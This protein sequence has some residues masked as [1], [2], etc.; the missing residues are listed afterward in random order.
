MESKILAFLEKGPRTNRELREAMKGT[1][2]SDARLDRDLQRMRRRGDLT[3]KNGRWF[4]TSVQVCSACGG[5]GW[6]SNKKA[7]TKAPAKK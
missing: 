7:P 3:V 1:K 5:K 6:V 2:A 4:A